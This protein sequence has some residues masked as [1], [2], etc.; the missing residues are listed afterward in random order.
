MKKREL[1]DK[2]KALNLPLWHYVI[3]GSW[4]MIAH[5]IK[6]SE[7]IDIVVSEELFNVYKQKDNWQKMPRT[8]PDKIW[9]IY[10]RQYNVELYLDVSCGN[11]NPTLSELISRAEIIENISFASLQDILKLKKEYSRTKT[12]HLEDIKKIEEYLK[13]TSY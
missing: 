3:V 8:Y 10:L 11:Y 4:S 6:E 7:D 13:V 5:N 1:I 12:K 9:E 2:I